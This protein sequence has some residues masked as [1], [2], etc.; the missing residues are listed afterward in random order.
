MKEPLYAHT[1]V[2]V[3]KGK[4]FSI[5]LYTLAQSAATKRESEL[6]RGG[7]RTGSV[8]EVGF[9]TSHTFISRDTVKPWVRSSQDERC[10]V[11]VLDG[12]KRTHIAT[13][14]SSFASDDIN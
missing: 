2:I 10:A 14:R 1:S 7:R 9:K 13:R 11:G 5:S 4:R 8:M 12:D 3:H 6:E